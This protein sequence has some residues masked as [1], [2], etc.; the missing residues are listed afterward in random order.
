MAISLL[1]EGR[2][3]AEIRSLE[4]AR[5]KR[6]KAQVQG[7]ALCRA[8]RHKWQTDKSTVFDSK[9]GKLVTREVC[10]RCGQTRV[11]AT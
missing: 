8:G 11:K 7:N 1:I 5:K 6:R 10:A 9:S 4:A 2:T 3:V